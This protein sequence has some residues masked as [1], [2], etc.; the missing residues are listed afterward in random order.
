MKKAKNIDVIY[1]F[2]A[3]M[4]EKVDEV[5]DFIFSKV[6]EYLLQ[7]KQNVTISGSHI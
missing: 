5:Y 4:G 2:S 1:E 3:D 7:Q 6:N